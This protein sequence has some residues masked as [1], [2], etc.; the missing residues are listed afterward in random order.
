[1]TDAEM[2]QTLQKNWSFSTL[3]SPHHDFLLFFV[4]LSLLKSKL[5]PTDLSMLSSKL[6]YLIKDK[7][8]LKVLVRHIFRTHFQIPVFDH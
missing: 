4:Q 5:S 8:K 6:P 1:M 2:I 3:G 7:I